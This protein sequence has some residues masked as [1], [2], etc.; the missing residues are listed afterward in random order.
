M[1]DSFRYPWKL[2][3]LLTTKYGWTVERLPPPRMG[4]LSIVHGLRNANTSVEDAAE[5]LNA[6]M[7]GDMAAYQTLSLVVDDNVLA[8]VLGSQFFG[9]YLMNDMIERSLARDEADKL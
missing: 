7:Y 2:H 1:F 9:N 5:I 8:D 3:K 6:A 4:W